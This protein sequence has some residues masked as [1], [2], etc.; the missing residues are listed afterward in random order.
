VIIPGSMGSASYLMA[1]SGNAEALAS[2]CHGAG[3][4]LARGKARQVDAETYERAV[5]RLRVVTPIDPGSPSLRG[6]HDILEQYHDR[7]KEEAPYA[8]KPITP[9]IETVAAAGIARPGARLGP[10]LAIKG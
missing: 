9:V 3:R 2:A 7:L 1:G 10:L 6:R 4:A 5:G 8:Y